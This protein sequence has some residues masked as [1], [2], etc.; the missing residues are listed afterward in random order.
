MAVAVAPVAQKVDR[1]VRAVSSDA[2]LD[3]AHDLLGR[4]RP[5]LR[6]TRQDHDESGSQHGEPKAA[7]YRRVPYFLIMEWQKGTD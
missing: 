2:A 7:R 1:A 5:G 4:L 3:A 6:W